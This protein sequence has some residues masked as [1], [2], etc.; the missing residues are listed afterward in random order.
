MSLSTPAKFLIASVAL[1]AAT[2][3][4]L[5]ALGRTAQKLRPTRSP[6]LEEVAGIALLGGFRAIAVD[7]LM[8]RAQRE[9]EEGRYYELLTVYE[10]VTRLVPRLESGWLYAA[11]NLALN[12]P[13]E[14][15]QPQLRWISIRQGIL[16]CE[17]GKSRNPASWR[18]PALAAYI[19]LQKWSADPHLRSRLMADGELNPEGFKRPERLALEKVWEA[20]S[21][22]GH[23]MSA[24][25]IAD[26]AL[27]RLTA[28]GDRL[29]DIE[30]FV[31]HLEQDGEDRAR[32]VSE[33]R[34]QIRK[35]RD[36]RK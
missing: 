33:W 17:K 25:I 27:E 14:V 5:G 11:G 16:L 30:R 2:L 34:A 36:G 9:M 24:D 8:L 31:A 35:I 6:G 19:M 3:P 15:D 13:A 21:I 4:I 28:G 20:I 10:A 26:Q 1:W 18:L 32:L 22:D 23:S 7:F 12:I 29:A